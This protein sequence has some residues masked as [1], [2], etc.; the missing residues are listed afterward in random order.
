M[1]LAHFPP[2]VRRLVDRHQNVGARAGIG[3]RSCT[4]L[5]TTSKFQGSSLV[6]GWSRISHWPVAC[7]GLGVS[8]KFHT[9]DQ[10]DVPRPLVKRGDTLMHGGKPAAAPDETLK[11]RLLFF[12]EHLART[13]EKDDGAISG[14]VLRGKSGG[15]FGG[16]DGKPPSAPSSRTAATPTGMCRGDIRRSWRRRVPAVPARCLEARFPSGTTARRLR[17]DS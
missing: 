10:G 17:V 12:V 15:V 11:R 1:V 7:W 13:V 5:Q 8:G 2:F 4:I 3:R 6:A 14:Q 9:A 16:V